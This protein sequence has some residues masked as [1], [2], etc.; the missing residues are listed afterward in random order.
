M[1]LTKG[2]SAGFAACSSDHPSPDWSA[3]LYLT[4]ENTAHEF[5]MVD[6]GAG[7]FVVSLTPA[8]TSTIAVGV[9]DFAV[10][11]TDGTEAAIIRRGRLEVLPDPT[12]AGDKRSQVEKDLAAVEQAI[13]D[14]IAGGAVQSYSIQTT[15]GQRQL[16][17][18]TLEELRA[19]RRRLIRQTG[20]S[21]DRWRPIKTRI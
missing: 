20:K 7:G 4:D 18:M 13:R 16:T 8:Q 21:A 6:D 19:E 9:K 15:V 3:T 14:I 10:K 1:T 12:L 17:R 2:T 5:P 11:V